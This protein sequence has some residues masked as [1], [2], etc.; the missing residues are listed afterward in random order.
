[1][2]WGNVNLV[3]VA[4]GQEVPLNKVVWFANT[5]TDSRLQ[6]A[7]LTASVAAKLPPGSVYAEDKGN[8][9]VWVQGQIGDSKPVCLPLMLHAVLPPGCVCA[10]RTRGP[11]RSLL[12]SLVYVARCR[13]GRVV[14]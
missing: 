2:L 13:E 11:H 9:I 10:R 8:G 4:M 5:Q 14:S 1:M 3:L 6:V 12:C 7:T